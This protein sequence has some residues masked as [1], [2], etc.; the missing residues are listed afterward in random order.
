[1]SNVHPLF[2]FDVW[3]RVQLEEK[4]YWTEL[5]FLIIV[6]VQ[7]DALVCVL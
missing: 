1:M 2:M 4:V 7:E 5:E 6:G 3:F